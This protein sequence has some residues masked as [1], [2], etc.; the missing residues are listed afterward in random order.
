MTSWVRTFAFT[1]EISTDVQES[2]VWFSLSLDPSKMQSLLD[3]LATLEIAELPDIA[4]SMVN[5]F[6]KWGKTSPEG[7][8]TGFLGVMEEFVSYWCDR[9]AQEFENMTYDDKKRSF[10]GMFQMDNNLLRLVPYGDEVPKIKDLLRDCMEK[11]R[12]SSLDL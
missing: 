9:S 11:T 7:G 5:W 8:R 1:L 10:R 12:V 2:D 4:L 6:D 3:T